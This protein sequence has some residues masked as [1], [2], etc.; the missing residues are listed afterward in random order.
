M[1]S[2]TDDLFHLFNQELAHYKSLPTLIVGDLNADPQ[3]IP[4]LHEMLANSDLTDV[5]ASADVHGDAHRVCD[6]T[7]ATH[8]TFLPDPKDGAR[9]AHPMA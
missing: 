5:G 7:C 8:A 1:I 2:M 6:N 4:T 9:V 3:D